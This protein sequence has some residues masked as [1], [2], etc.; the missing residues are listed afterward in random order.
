MRVGTEQHLAAAGHDLTG[1]L[2]DDCLMRGYEH[3]AVLLGSC[4]TENVVIFI[5]GSA[6]CA[7]RVV[8]AGK[9]VI[10]RE[11]GHA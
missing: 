8:A 4:Q 9:S 6:Y 10:K 7:K 5:D 3:S 1:I 2:M 11:L